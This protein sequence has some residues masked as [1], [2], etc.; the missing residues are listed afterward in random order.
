MNNTGKYHPLFTY[1]GIF[2]TLVFTLMFSTAHLIM[3]D[4]GNIGS[5]IKN[6][7]PLFLIIFS[8]VLVYLQR[9]SEV[10]FTRVKSGFYIIWI[11]Y[12]ISLCINDIT[13]GDFS[14]I[15]VVAYILISLIFL[16]KIPGELIIFML[17]GGLISVFILLAGSPDSGVSVS[18]TLIITAGLILIPKNNQALLLYLMPSA[19]VLLTIPFNTATLFTAAGAFSA[20]F[21]IINIPPVKNY[22]RVVTVFLITITVFTM[23]YINKF[24]VEEQISLNFFVGFIETNSVL[25]LILLVILSTYT[26]AISFPIHVLE[27]IFLY[28]ITFLILLFFE[29]EYFTEQFIF[30]PVIILILLLSI[31]LSNDRKD[32]YLF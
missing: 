23:I 19:A 12:V 3:I 27:T 18:A 28:F 11:M 1:E 8:A 22:L 2:L 5:V 21:L 29:T 10:V 14:L 13:A 6:E 9:N 17:T 16:F 20:Y 7:T 30:T 15:K 26:A 24:T 32:D 4:F 31:I 25:T